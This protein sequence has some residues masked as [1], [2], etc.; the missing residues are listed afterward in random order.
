MKKYARALVALTVA[1]AFV[2]L[3]SVTSFAR[4]PAL[5]KALAGVFAIASTLLFTF[6]RLL[7]TTTGAGT[8]STKEMARFTEKRREIRSRFWRVFLACA[9]SSALL[10]VLGIYTET[11]ISDDAALWIP[12]LAGLLLGV[13]IGYLLTVMKWID[14]LSAF[15][16]TLRQRE[17][18]VKDHEALV[19]RLADARKRTGGSSA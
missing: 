8:L 18:R 12:G 10:W 4:E 15:A 13:S 2:A 16:D 14:E 17:Q 19:K 7:A 11:K 3:A 9:T 5:Y 1:G 6:F